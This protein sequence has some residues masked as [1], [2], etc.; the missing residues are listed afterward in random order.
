MLDVTI[1]DLGDVVVL[2]C[3]GRIVGGYESDILRLEVLAQSKAETVA[4]D[5]SQVEMV[6]ARGIGTLISLQVWAHARGKTL[7]LMNSSQFVLEL[8]ELTNLDSVFE[9]FLSKDAALNEALA[10]MPVYQ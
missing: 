4:L 3:V 10:E 1:Q 2:R 5:L 8:F 6:D 7:Q 9:I